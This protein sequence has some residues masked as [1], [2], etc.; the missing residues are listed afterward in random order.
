M[1]FCHNILGLLTCS[2]MKYKFKKKESNLLT[3]TRSETLS[4]VYQF[5]ICNTYVYI[6]MYMDVSKAK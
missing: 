5:E 2:L 3:L 4:G 1:H 6:R